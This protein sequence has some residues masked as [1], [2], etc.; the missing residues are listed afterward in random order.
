[1]PE[2]AFPPQT[3]EI[4]RRLLDEQF[5]PGLAQLRQM[6]SARSEPTEDYHQI[7]L[8]EKPGDPNTHSNYGAFLK[9]KKG[10]DAGAERAYARALELDPSH[11]N[12]LGNLANLKREQGDTAAAEALYRK[13][14]ERSHIMKTS[15]S[16][17]RASWTV[18]RMIGSTPLPFCAPESL[19]IPTAADHTCSLAN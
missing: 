19:T 2:F 8:R 16:T 11:V 9:D 7:Q 15:L 5:G 17:S 13:A 14:L 18:S 6:A 12:A 1:V 3:R 4:V 10:D